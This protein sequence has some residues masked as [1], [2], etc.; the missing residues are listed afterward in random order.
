MIKSNDCSPLLHMCQDQYHPLIVVGQ[1]PLKI[2]WVDQD[3][4]CYRLIKRPF[5]S[6]QVISTTVCRTP[7]WLLQTTSV[8]VQCPAS[9]R[10]PLLVPGAVWASALTRVPLPT[11]A[12]HH[13]YHALAPLTSHWEAFSSNKSSE[14]DQKHLSRIS[15]NQFNPLVKLGTNYMWVLNIQKHNY[16]PG[17][18]IT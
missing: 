15:L 1:G 18:G 13:C 11:P 17:V 7:L 12:P 8:P 4:L 2:S 10:L 6:G 14:P 3:T 16:Q 9:A 5:T